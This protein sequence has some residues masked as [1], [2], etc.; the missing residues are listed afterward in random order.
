MLAASASILALGVVSPAQ[1][2]AADPG[3]RQEDS[4][5]IAINLYEL[6]LT[7]PEQ[8]SGVVTSVSDP[9]GP[10]VAIAEV[11]CAETATCSEVGAVEQSAIGTQSASNGIDI[12]GSHTIRAEADAYGT[13]ASAIGYIDLAV[14]QLA[15]APELATNDISIGGLLD[16]HASA[17]AHAITGGAF[18]LAAVP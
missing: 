4:G 5:T 2:L 12:D 6:D 1:A 15:V 7:D 14:G 11:L 10:A 8:V 3:V 16:V 9:S 17:D 13:A 18:A